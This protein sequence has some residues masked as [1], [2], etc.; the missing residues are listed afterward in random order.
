MPE[1]ILPNQENTGTDLASQGVG[2]KLGK[3][4]NNRF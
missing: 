2:L 4:Q 3:E 1:E